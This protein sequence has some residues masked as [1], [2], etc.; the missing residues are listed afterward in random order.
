MYSV[1]NCMNTDSRALFAASLF[2]YIAAISCRKMLRRITN[3]H[4]SKPYI[5]SLT[6]VAVP[7]PPILSKS[8]PI[9]SASAGD[10]KQKQEFEETESDRLLLQFILASASYNTSLDADYPPTPNLLALAKSP[11]FPIYNAD[12]ST[13]FHQL[14]LALLKRFEK[15]LATLNSCLE[16]GGSILEAAT[17]TQ[18]YGYGLL[19]LARGQAFRM[20]MEHIGHL[21]KKP[22]PT[23]AGE[24]VP[25]SSNAEYPVEEPE[26]EDLQAL[27]SLL[28]NEGAA[29]KT[30]TKSYINWLRLTVAHFDAVEIIIQYV[31]SS[32]FRYRE[33]SAMTLVPPSTS[34]ALCPWEE[35][36]KDYLPE[37]DLT[38]LSSSFT[39]SNQELLIFLQENRDKASLAKKIS[40]LADQALTLWNER[41][42]PD[43]KVRVLHTKLSEI[44]QFGGAAMRDTMRSML[45]ALKEW[46]KGK[47]EESTQKITS[48]IQGLYGRFFHI[49]PGASFFTNL[50]NL[51]FGGK[52]HCEAC[53]ATLIYNATRPVPD[54]NKYSE[55]LKQMAVSMCSDS[56]LP[57]TLT[58]FFVMTIDFWTNTW[59]IETL[60]PSMHSLP[61][62][63]DG[64]G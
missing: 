9:P 48:G 39:V 3:G 56:F 16:G 52:M 7:I 24:P 38:S 22:D 20:H 63:A 4:V 28:P 21:L 31:W 57:L 5:Q 6:K 51:K 61:Q 34:S 59:G 64:G 18:L 43:F 35:V 41:D 19:K 45:D 37:A 50:E 13:E 29:P 53:L 47:D 44:G 62:A 10:V 46:D 32:S 30:L 11:A 26:D 36:V 55:V 1:N 49:P 2:R 17:D 60:L 33:I 12:T 40:P 15:A 27:E 58:F 23:N 25:A 14:L 42:D 54:D 8:I